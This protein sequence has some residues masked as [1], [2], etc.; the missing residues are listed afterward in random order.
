M[1]QKE[2]IVTFRLIYIAKN[3]G[4]DGE[5]SIQF[6]SET[7][8]LDNA[9][10]DI[11][12][13]IEIE[14]YK[15]SNPGDLLCIAQLR[16][17]PTRKISLWL[18]N[19]IGSSPTG[20]KE[21][22][23]DASQSLSKAITTALQLLRW[24]IGYRS[25]RNPIR[26]FHSFQWSINN[27]T[28][29]TVPNYIHLEF[30]EGGIYD[31]VTDEVVTTLN[32][33]WHNNVQEPLDHELFQEAWSQRSNNPKSALVISVAAA[34]TGMKQLI[35]KLVPSTTWLV[36]NTQ[37]P[38]LVK[39]L[40]EYLPTLPAKVKILKAPPPALPNAFVAIIEKAV[41][42]RNEIVHGKDVQLESKLLNEILKT[43]N[44]LLYIFDLYL[45]HVWAERRISSETKKAW[46]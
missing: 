7:D 10:I 11:S 34:E 43:I 21:F 27:N 13:I 30:V 42:L 32:D 12:H 44:D 16:K 8:D 3:V 6:Q 41:L 45:G 24:R 9:K 5:R 22:A 40:K 2:K 36:Q 35:S 46:Y 28:W 19:P 4:L 25:E 14:K 17:K 23:D 38:P 1:S 26:F 29:K 15:G 20:F 31:K 18:E 33:L 39:M 37:S